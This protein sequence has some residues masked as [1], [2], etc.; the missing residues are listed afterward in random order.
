[1]R[2]EGGGPW[3][4]FARL[5]RPRGGHGPRGR[6][7]P[8][9]RLPARAFLHNPLKG[10]RGVRQFMDRWQEKCQEPNSVLGHRPHG[11]FGPPKRGPSNQKGSRHPQSTHRRPVPKTRLKLTRG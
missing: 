10:R 8:P 4:H 11:G 3:T 2:E 7:L 5:L 1:M 6:A 9:G